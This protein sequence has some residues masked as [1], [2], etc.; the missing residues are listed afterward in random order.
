MTTNE[1][2]K[3]LPGLDSAPDVYA[4]PDFNDDVTE[5]TNE[6]SPERGSESDTSHE[7]GEDENDH[8]INRRRLYPE[9]ARSRFGAQSRGTEGERVG[10]LA[11][12]RNRRQE[13]DEEPE[14][15]DA[16][17]ARLRRELEECRLE[18]KAE[19]AQGSA[20]EAENEGGT[21]DAIDALS[22]MMSALDMVPVKRRGHARTRSAYHDAPTIPPSTSEQQPQPQPQQTQQS[23]QTIAP[24]DQTL[25][26]ITAFDTRLAAIETA[27]GISTLDAA[28]EISALT[29]PLLPTI[30]L[31]DHQV[32]TLTSATSLAALEAA[33]TKIHKLKSEAAELAHMQLQSTTPSDAE[34]D[35]DSEAHSPAAAALS[36]ED[37]ASLKSL[38][39]ILP[40]L[41]SLSPMVPALANRL[42]SLR[43]IHTA[44]ANAHN[45][46]NE[47]EEMQG[48]MDKELKMWREGLEK[49][50]EAVENAVEQNAENG[51]FVRQWVEELDGRV[52]GLRR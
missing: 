32:A 30:A 21:L 27:L 46:L 5:S 25:T 29:S 17:I 38:Y 33:S 15:L 8:G 24:D 34:S 40:T 43:T 11:G 7:D 22:R 48:E 10:V 47:L 52:K 35:V 13:E 49:V 2:R 20:E 28:T 31:L 26:N 23:E 36:A 51:K 9:R 4:T 16:K 18:A 12:R 37:M 39:A 44:A 45:D 50:E 1:A 42:R 6:T 14:T 41:Q 3:E 19:Q